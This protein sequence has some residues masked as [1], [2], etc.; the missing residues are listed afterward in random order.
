MLDMPS[1]SSAMEFR[2]C[3][4]AAEAGSAVGAETGSASSKWGAAQNQ[5]PIAAEI[6]LIL[7]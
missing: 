5:N 2:I 1:K 6:E 3:A 4:E 7:L